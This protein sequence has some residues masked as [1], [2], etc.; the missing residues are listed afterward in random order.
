MMIENAPQTFWYYPNQSEYGTTR[1]HERGLG[2]LLLHTLR[3]LEYSDKLCDG[4]GVSD[5]ER[6]IV[7]CATLV[8]D[9]SWTHLVWLITMILIYI[10]I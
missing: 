3:T 6:D 10:I 8:H 9:F 1:E 7:L 4:W 5:F 2:G